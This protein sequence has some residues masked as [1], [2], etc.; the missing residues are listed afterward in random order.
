MILIMPDISHHYIYVVAR[1]INS[2]S[3]LLESEI[4]L[5]VIYAE[6]QFKPVNQQYFC[7]EPE[8]GKNMNCN[9]LMSF[10]MLLIYIFF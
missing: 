10:H 2:V 3:G 1:P 8:G 7:N 4:I 6:I 9:T 5:L